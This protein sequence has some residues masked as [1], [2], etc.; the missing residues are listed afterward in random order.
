MEK[1]KILKICEKYY[2]KILSKVSRFLGWLLC[3][4]N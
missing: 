4:N 1:N 3:N 2:E